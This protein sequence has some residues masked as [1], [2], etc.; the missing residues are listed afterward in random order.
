MK[1]F[2]KFL[3]SLKNKVFI[4]KFSKN[5]KNLPENCN[6]SRNFREIYSKLLWRPGAFARWTPYEGCVIAFKWPEPSSPPGK[7]FGDSTPPRL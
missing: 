5:R 3:K 1:D 4:D 2:S 7:K 6:F